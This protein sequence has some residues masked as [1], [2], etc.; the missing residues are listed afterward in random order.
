MPGKS[1]QNENEATVRRLFEEMDKGNVNVLDELSTPDYLLHFPEIPGAM[2]REEAK[3]LF[4]ELYV[5]FPGLR[6]AIEDQVA[7]GGYV[8]ARVVLR[9]TRPGASRGTPP[10]RDPVGVRS[11]NTFHFSGGKLAEQWVEF[12][13]AQLGSWPRPGNRKA[14]RENKE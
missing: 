11:I 3:R 2:H 9:A 1:T 8:A 4:K 7:G 6:H 5:A 14:D 12:D 10:K 13:L